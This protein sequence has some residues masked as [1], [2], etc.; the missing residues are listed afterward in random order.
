M[1][2]WLGLG[3]AGLF[4]PA[5]ALTILSFRRALSRRN[6]LLVRIKAD[7][8]A[9]KGIRDDKFFGVVADDKEMVLYKKNEE[10][11]MLPSGAL[12]CTLPEVRCQ[13]RLTASRSRL[14]RLR[15]QAPRRCPESGS[16][17]R[18]RQ[19]RRSPSRR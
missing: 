11:R 12:A 16:G 8:S 6:P 4:F 13:V 14:G 5:P 10:R 15:K 1:T 17:R 18:C 19:P 7:S 9:L 3:G 2:R